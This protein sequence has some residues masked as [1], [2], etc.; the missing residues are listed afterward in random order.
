V[1]VNMNRVGDSESP[2]RTPLLYLNLSDLSEFR[3]RKV[4]VEVYKLEMASAHSFRFRISSIFKIV[5]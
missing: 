5:E 3:S 2:W 4:S 1:R